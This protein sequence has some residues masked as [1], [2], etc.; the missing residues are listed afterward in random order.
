VLPFRAM[1]SSV[2]KGLPVC[3]Q[4]F[5]RI[6][7]GG[8]LLPGLF[9]SSLALGCRVNA[10][11]HVAHYCAHRIAGLGKREGAATAKRDAALLPVRVV[12]SEV[13]FAAPRCHPH[14]KAALLVIENEYV[15][16]PGW[17]SQSVNTIERELHGAPSNSADP[18]RTRQNVIL[19]AF[20]VALCQQD[21]WKGF[22]LQWEVSGPRLAVSC[23][24]AI[25]A[26]T[27]NQRVQGSS[28]CAPTN[29]IKLLR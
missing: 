27:L 13:G 23:C 24:V 7:F 18:Q 25:A 17:A 3:K 1:A 19:R 6:G 11:C 16:A 21:S 26:L 9:R 20:S 4:F 14:S 12:L 10:L 8:D 5:E 28:P 22:L 29:E 2:L 15:L